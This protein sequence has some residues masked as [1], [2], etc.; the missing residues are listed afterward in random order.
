MSNAKS[1]PARRASPARLVHG[2]T[3]SVRLQNSF[4]RQRSPTPSSGRA[5]N[6]IAARRAIDMRSGTASFDTSRHVSSGLV[7]AGR[8]VSS[9]SSGRDEGRVP[10][11]S[12]SGRGWRHEGVDPA[13]QRAFTPSRVSQLLSDLRGHCQDLS[14]SSGKVAQEFAIEDIATDMIRLMDRGGSGYVDARDLT[15]FMSSISDACHSKGSVVG[16][17]QE[18]DRDG[19]GKLTQE[20]LATFMRA[21]MSQMGRA[22]LVSALLVVA[23]HVQSPVF[24]V[25]PTF[26]DL[27]VGAGCGCIIP[28]TE[29]RAVTQRQLRAVLTHVSR[30]CGVEGWC[31]QCDGS[32]AYGQPLHP[33]T[34]NLYQVVDLVV[35]P[36]TKARR[37]SFVEF[38]AEKPQPPKWFVSHWWGEAVSRFVACLR[39]HSQD[40]N[41]DWNCPYWICAYANNQ[42]NI[43]DELSAHDPGQTP[44][45][46]AIDLSIG[47][48]SILDEEAACFGRIWC[49]F[50]A[51]ISIVVEKD[52]LYDIYTLSGNS[53]V[54]ITDGVAHADLVHGEH[55]ANDLKCERERLFPIAGIQR[56]LRIRLQDA[57][58]SAR[59]DRRHILNSIVG[60]RDLNVEPPEEHPRY[61]ELNSSLRA[62]FA[63]AA[64]RNALDAGEDMRCYRAVLAT[65]RLKRFMVS[66]TRCAALTN[67]Q[68]RLLADGMP[69]TLQELSLDFDGCIAV[70]DD[71]ASPLSASLPAGLRKLRLNF[72]CCSGLTSRSFLGIAA[73]LPKGLVELVLGCGRCGHALSDEVLGA[74]GKALPAALSS[75]SLD[76]SNCEAISD[77]GVEALV[78]AMPS[79]MKELTLRVDNCVALSDRCACAFGAALPLSLLCLSASFDGCSALSDEG[80]AALAAA[81]SPLALLDLRLSF[82]KCVALTDEGLV[83]VAASLSRSMR[84]MS[85]GFGGCFALSDS[86]VQALV[87]GLPPALHELKL[88]FSGC[89][90]LSVDGTLRPLGAGLPSALRRV[91]LNFC[92]CC[93]IA[94]AD[95]TAEETVRQA[96]KGGGTEL[97]LSS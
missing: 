60:S 39:Q 24:A 77:C 96:L 55:T 50:E 91:E 87:A 37:C 62:R 58:A 76:L 92:N 20:E 23:D 34:I 59:R 84:K 1:T 9:F 69:A 15:T 18:M 86:S 2:A 26:R 94:G 33:Q 36:A 16:S 35:K 80:L 21:A 73:A 17:F 78:A 44:F 12:G 42:W 11:R 8:A 27:V 64:W 49:G 68:M 65:S 4:G 66:F 51:W 81:L 10:R 82:G 7:R 14:A 67:D 19:D 47:T 57:A 70:T 90:T 85:L 41:F 5:S 48:V 83:A 43:D 28:L 13:A 54:G 52:Q 30:R 45:R 88:D 79:Q 22:R 95:T 72:Y 3:T 61:D 6:T 56:A 93:C 74:L 31:D 46:R 38:V 32:P 89:P 29:E 75:F 53:A 71:G 40:R 63:A 97:I 25:D